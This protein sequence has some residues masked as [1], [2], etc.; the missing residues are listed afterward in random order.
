MPALYST[1]AIPLYFTVQVVQ[2]LK[3]EYKNCSRL[4][5]IMTENNLF[6]IKINRYEDKIY[7]FGGIDRN[8]SVVR[9]LFER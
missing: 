3:R 2:Y 5:V 4:F 7:L 9:F 8:C 1:W 6:T